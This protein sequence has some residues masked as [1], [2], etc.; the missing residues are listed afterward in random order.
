[1]TEP[2]PADAQVWIFW[3]AVWILVPG[4]LWVLWKLLTFLWAG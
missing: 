2:Q 4:A 3:A 1:M